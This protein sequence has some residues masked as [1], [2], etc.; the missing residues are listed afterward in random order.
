MIEKNKQ[1]SFFSLPSGFRRN[2]LKGGFL[3]KSP[4]W[5]ED[6]KNKNQKC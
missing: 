4:G 6:R 2:E 3:K 5:K 1:Y